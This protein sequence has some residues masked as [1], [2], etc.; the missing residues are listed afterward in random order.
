M[1]TYRRDNG[2]VMEVLVLV[3]EV[4]EAQVDEQELPVARVHK[5]L[6]PVQ[7]QVQEQEE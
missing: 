3:L 2:V 6:L 7:V 5:L 1:W 4:Q